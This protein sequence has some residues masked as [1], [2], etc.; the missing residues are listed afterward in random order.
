MQLS[1]QVSIFPPSKT[2]PEQPKKLT[3]SKTPLSFSFKAMSKDYFD[4]IPAHQ[5]IHQ[6]FLRPS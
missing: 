2:S 5:N 3:N 4:T 6:L 1:N